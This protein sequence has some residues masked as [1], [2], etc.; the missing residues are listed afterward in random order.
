MNAQSCLAVM[1]L[2]LQLW[3]LSYGYGGLS[4]T[5]MDRK[6]FAPKYRAHKN[7]SSAIPFRVGGLRGWRSI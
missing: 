2:A 5:G 1:G 3:G 6:V 7:A 4:E